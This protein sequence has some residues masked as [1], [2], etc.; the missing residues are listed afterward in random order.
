M[1]AAAMVLGGAAAATQGATDALFLRGVLTVGL[2]LAFLLVLVV[3]WLSVVHDDGDHSCAGGTAHAWADAPLGVHHC[4]YDTC[5]C[6]AV[7]CTRC[8]ARRNRPAG[9]YDF[10][11]LPFAVRTVR[12]PSK[13]S[14][15]REWEQVR[16]RF[17][18]EEYA[19]AFVAG[20]ADPALFEVVASERP[21][22]TPTSLLRPDGTGMAW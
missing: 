6:T 21:G 1:S 22:R 7:V 19:Q 10:T 9:D 18:T 8:S 17:A 3:I 4:G 16:G 12:V 13:R 5:R 11:A 14:A 15:R 2:P 20:L